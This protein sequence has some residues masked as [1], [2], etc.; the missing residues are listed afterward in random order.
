MRKVQFV[1]ICSTCILVGVFVFLLTYDSTIYPKPLEGIF[2]KAGYN[3]FELKKVIRHYSRS[4]KDSLKKRAAIFLIKNMDLYSSYRSRSWDNCQKELTGLFIKECNEDKLNQGFDSIYKKYD[5]SDVVYISDLKRVK[6]QFLIKNID[7]AFEKW[8]ISYA[9]Q[10]NFDEFCE[11]VLPYRA[12]N[13]PLCDWHSIFNAQYVPNL[14]SLINKPK[15]TISAEDICMKLRIVKDGCLHPSPPDM[16]DYNIPTLLNAKVG[17]CKQFCLKAILSARCMGVPVAIDF[18]PQWA[19]RSMGHEWNVLITP[20]GKPLC[21]GVND[22][23]KLGMHI[24]N[25]PDRIPPKVYRKTFGRQ[26]ESL[27]MVHGNEEIPPSLSS[28]C[29][30]DIT[31]DYYATVDIVVNLDV[32]PPA[33]NHFVYL[34]VFN[35][36]EWIPVSWSYLHGNKVKFKDLHKGIV[37]LPG[38]FYNRQFLPAAPPFIINNSGKPILLIPNLKKQQTLVLCRKYQNALVNDYCK[39]MIGGVFQGANKADFSDAVNLFTIREQPDACYNALKIRKASSCKYFRYL[40]A[41]QK[42]CNIAEIEVYALA[43]H[44]KLRGKILGGY[45]LSPDSIAG[46]PPLVTVPRYIRKPDKQQKMTLSIS[47]LS[48]TIM[49]KQPLRHS[50]RYTSFFYDLVGSSISTGI[51][52]S[53]VK[54]DTRYANAFDGDPLTNYVREGCEQTWVGLEFDKPNRI[55]RIVYL[56]RNDDNGIRYGDIYELFFWDKNWVSLGKQTG[57]NETYRLTYQ[58]A[59]IDALFL[60]RNLTRGN[61]ERIFTYEKGKQVWW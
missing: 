42:T 43:S 32:R 2:E 54:T 38:Y 50:N 3:Q 37:C 23:C 4:P 29:M 27:A 45:K 10:L 16:P 17:A 13:A 22:K 21:F 6:A 51:T 61:E 49:Y 44:S 47:S 35:N 55:E 8:K 60:L 56:P 18:T 28:P 15:H 5:L 1:I 19:N 39:N 33:R 11:Y 30:K 53:K 58:K 20:K 48:C 40:A 41:K 14:I 25:V 59:P 7:Y 34:A 36:K 46:L 26:K 24:E 31:R 52:S 9:K 12:G 57:N